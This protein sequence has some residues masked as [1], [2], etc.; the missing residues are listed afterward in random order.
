[1]EMKC[2]GTSYPSLLPSANLLQPLPGCNSSFFFLFSVRTHSVK[3]ATRV[4]VGILCENMTDCPEVQ[5]KE[6]SG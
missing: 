6:R 3:T 2:S 5:M 1:M 4:D